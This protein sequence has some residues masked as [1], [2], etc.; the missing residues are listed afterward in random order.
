MNRNSITNNYRIVA[1]PNFCNRKFVRSIS[2]KVLKINKCNLE[3]V[4]EGFEEKNVKYITLLSV[5]YGV[6]LISNFA[7]LNL[8]GTYL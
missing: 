7:I 8:V 1:L 6:I 5:F 4:I 2:L 3:T